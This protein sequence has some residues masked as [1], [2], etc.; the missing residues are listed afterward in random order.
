MLNP[1]KKSHGGKKGEEGG[2]CGAE[3]AKCTFHL[4]HTSEKGMLLSV[5]QG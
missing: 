5:L 1:K 2:G 3:P 4:L